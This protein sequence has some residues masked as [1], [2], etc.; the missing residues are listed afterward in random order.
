M[1]S[2]IKLTVQDHSI[3]WFNHFLFLW[4]PWRSIC[5]RSK[6]NVILFF[7]FLAASYDMGDQIPNQGSHLCPYQ[8]YAVEV[9]ILNHWTTREVPEEVMSSLNTKKLRLEEESRWW[10]NRTGRSLSLLQIHRKNNR[11]VN[12][13]Y[14][15]TSDR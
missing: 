6:V 8:A 7:S 11:M 5:S 14:K 3:L 12:K 10:R 9:R 1:W 2:C 4:L 13:V 15:T